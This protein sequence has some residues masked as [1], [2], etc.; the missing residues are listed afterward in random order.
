MVYGDLI[1]VEHT[2]PLSCGPPIHLLSAR[3][4]YIDLN[5]PMSVLLAQEWGWV[6]WIWS[7]VI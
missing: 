6:G 1:M 4:R 5:H 3:D 2:D 7:V